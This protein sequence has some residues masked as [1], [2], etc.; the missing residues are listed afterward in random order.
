[1]LQS[2]ERLP[3]LVWGSLGLP[4]PDVTE[5][6]LTQLRPKGRAARTVSAYL[7]AIGSG[8]AH[9][10]RARF[11]LEER[12]A[13][14][15]Y[16]TTPEL[17]AFASVCKRGQKKL[18]IDKDEAASRYTRFIEYICWRAE[19]FIGRASSEGS[20]ERGRLALER[21]KTRARAVAPPPDT[22]ISSPD[23]R[24]GLTKPQRGLL[25][26]VIQ[27]SDDRNPWSDPAL[28]ARNFAMVQ[29]AYELG[30]RAGDVLSLKIRDLNITHRPASV[31]FHRRHDDPDDPRKNQP[32]LKTKP[33]VL[34]I[35]DEL[36][37][38]LEFW[39][40]RIRANRVRF[41]AAR[42][43][44]FVFTNDR[45][46]PLG[47]RGYQ[48]VF[49]KLRTQFP[50]LGELVSHVLRYDWNERWHDLNADAPGQSASS[51]RE[52]CYAMGWAD[53]STMPAR[54]SRRAIAASANK[55]IARMNKSAQARG[56]QDAKSKGLK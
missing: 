36:A 22:S 43:H 30:P 10:Q 53:R 41:P 33:R 18:A 44:P 11:G 16:L 48:L 56:E 45:G 4:E 46:H 28:R 50:E 6:V 47:E 2:G 13:S 3:L 54:Y 51:Q 23:A 49:K 12:I 35:S 37:L 7:R 42:R 25:L 32:V 55:K 24:T 31:T 19:L 21:F 27:P 20:F 39:I 14:G 40:D 1:M 15:A 29:L 8:L 38:A 26:A 5:F 17:T 9:L 52:Q 34:E